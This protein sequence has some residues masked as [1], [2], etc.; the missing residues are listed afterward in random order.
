MSAETESWRK[1]WRWAVVTTGWILVFVTAKIAVAEHGPI[2]RP[3]VDPN[4]PTYTATGDVSGNL[5]LVGSD[6]MQPLLSRLV[7]EFRRYH[8]SAMVSVEGGGSSAA[9]KE[10]LERSPRSKPFLSSA[11]DEPIVLVASSRQ[12]SDSE[13]KQFVSKRG[14]HPTALPV[15]V[16]A[17]GI[18]VHRDNPLP[19]LT[20]EQVDAMFSTTRHRG[21]LREIKQWG[22]LGFNTD[23]KNTPITLYGRDEKSGTRAFIREHVLENG[24]FRPGIHEE[25]GAASVILALSRDPFGIG[26]SGIGLQAS[27][28]RAV[29]LA[30]KEGMPYV[31][32]RAEAVMD[33]SYPLRRFLY[34]YADKSPNTPLPA[35]AEAFLVFV[36]SHE[37]QEAVI[38]AG[39]YP[40]PANYLQQSLA[41]LTLPARRK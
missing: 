8:Q 30:D 1:T 35:I 39:F 14:Y 32:P 10:F 17:V 16:D 23:W 6:T 9:V 40:L 19:H 38:R 22:Q 24:E 33:E 4:L 13:L 37:G 25:P 2:D 41:A 15:A 20:L 26:Y 36:T 5:K 27:G 7:R 21:Y 31:Q 12:L 29:P 34:L 18:Y 11:G 28:V 3:A